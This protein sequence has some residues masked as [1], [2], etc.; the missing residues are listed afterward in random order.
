MEIPLLIAPFIQDGLLTWPVYIVHHESPVTILDVVEEDGGILFTKYSGSIRQM[1]IGNWK[2]LSSFRETEVDLSYPLGKHLE[3]W[4]TCTL[5]ALG[6]LSSSGKSNADILVVGLGGGSIPAFLKLYAPY[7]S[8]ECVEISKLVAHSSLEFFK[9]NAELCN[10]AKCQC[11][12]KNNNKVTII[13]IDDIN[14]FVSRTTNKYDCILL[15]VYTNSTFPSSLLNSI[16]FQKLKE[17]QNDNGVLAV[18]SGGEL[19]K[20]KSLMDEIYGSKVKILCEF[21][22]NERVIVGGLDDISPESWMELVS[23]KKLDVPFQL[24]KYSVHENTLMIG[25]GFYDGK[26]G[27]V[28]KKSE[29]NSKQSNDPVPTLVNTEAEDPW[30]LFE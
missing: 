1:V 15:D 26:E 25:W 8:L 19:E 9:L 22:G 4:Y 28:D 12:T 27:F 10:A 14:S 18:N 3:N 11:S 5:A 13:H 16:F 30:A 7:L 20:I 23:D 24:E 17:I 2:G 21:K 6:L 29:T